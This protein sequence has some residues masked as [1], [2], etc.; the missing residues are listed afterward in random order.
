MNN[1]KGV[2]YKK[3]F[4]IY[5]ILGI[6][7][8]FAVLLFDPKLDTGGDNAHYILLGKSILN[9]NGYK[10]IFAP[11]APPHT[12]YPPMYPLLLAGIMAIAGDKFFFL[13]IFSLFLCL[14][15]IYIFYLIVRERLSILSYAVLFIFAISPSL[16]H[17]SHLVLSEPL[18]LFF[19]VLTIYL[20][21]QWES[22]KKRSY[23][24]FATLSAIACYF[25]RT[26]GIA[27]IIGGI[28]Y[29][30]YRR[31]FKGTLAF[32]LIALA[33][34]LPQIVRNTRVSQ[35][36]GYFTQF[37]LKNPYDIKSGYVAISDIVTRVYT[38][39]KI[40][41]ISVIPGFIFPS[42]RKLTPPYKPL[43]SGIVIIGLIIW[44][45]TI[46][47]LVKDSVANRRLVHFFL[48]FYAIITLG[49]PSV[50]SC[51]RF[52]FPVL[53]FILF[54]FFAGISKIASKYL[55]VP[56]VFIGISAFTSLWTTLPKIPPNIR[57]LS[58]YRKGDKMAGYSSDWRNYYLASD[59]IRL[60]TKP[61]AVVMCR[62]P[63]LFY[64]RANRK[65]F[66]YPMTYEHQQILDAINKS[67]YI[68]VDH[69]FWTSTTPRYLIPVL[70]E[71]REIFTVVY[72]TYQ[73]Q[74]LVLRVKGKGLKER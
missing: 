17:N 23:F 16:L 68:L 2:F 4:L 45:I 40:Y 61:D 14:G 7:T 33:F 34:I 49:W 32:L 55:V 52:L 28:V 5:I 36:Q 10:D 27:I 72:A 3:K 19:T 43:N 11:D 39:F 8:I 22:N 69:F 44:G 35:E 29:L 70:K 42:Y 60:N 58:Y 65:T 24:L 21:N 50:W 47:G 57:M 67:D 20:S 26:I 15:S 71:N 41:A 38:N 59:W 1:L 9:G 31:K 30:L 66:C 13:E 37:F 51:E 12:Q 64:L 46:Y 54:Y 73:P 53:P 56:G 74:T 18:F 6:S 25:V 63:T 62:K 48:L